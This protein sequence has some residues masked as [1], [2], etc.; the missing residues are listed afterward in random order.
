MLA[1]WTVA[2]KGLGRAFLCK[3]LRFEPAAE[4]TGKGVGA[5]IDIGMSIIGLISFSRQEESLSARLLRGPG[6]LFTLS[7]ALD[8]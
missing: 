7:G 3:H 6:G 2:V 8:S 4:S 5:R 1:R